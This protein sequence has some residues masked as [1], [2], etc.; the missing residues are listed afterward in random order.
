MHINELFNLKGK[1][2]IVTGG[3]RGIGLMMAEGFAEAGASL[4]I[5]A[6]S[7]DKCEE[8]AGMQQKRG[9][10]CNEMRCDVSK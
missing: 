10:E 4:V 6:R 5:C 2:A 1:T 8:S 9:I 3:S 7:L